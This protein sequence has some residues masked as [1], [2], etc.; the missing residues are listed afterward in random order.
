MNSMARTSVSR[1]VQ[2]GAAALGVICI[3][4]CSRSQQPV[5]MA[6]PINQGYQQGNGQQ[7][8]QSNM[9]PPMNQGSQQN[10]GNLQTAGVYQWQDVPQGQSVQVQ[11][12]TFDQGGY[13]IF[14]STGETIVVPFV[15]QNLYALKFGRTNGQSYFV[16]DGQAPTLYLPPGGYLENASAQNARWYPIPADYSYTQPMYVSVAPSWSEYVGMGWYP[17]MNYYGGMWGYHPYSSFSWMPGFYVNIGGSRY[18][19]YTSYHTYYTRNPGYT[20][21]NTVY[22][23]YSSPRVSGFGTNRSVGSQGSFGNRNRSS[24]STAPSGSTGSFGNRR[25]TGGSGN[26][27]SGRGF[28]QPS[29]TSGFRRPSN[30]GSFGGTRSSSGSFGGTRSSSGSFGTRSSGGSF[31]GRRR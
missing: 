20:R 31:G 13:Q 16:N 14:A 28:S 19:S 25:T 30:S 5:N 2:L 21:L 7:M 29:G 12:A 3:S 11:R 18:S 10:G 26:S 9:A 17:G 1:A 27:S 4:G 24:F 22:R 23:N 15:N 8:G 6:P